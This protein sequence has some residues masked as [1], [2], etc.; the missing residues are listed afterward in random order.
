MDMN[1][2]ISRKWKKISMIV[3]GMVGLSTLTFNCAP[4]MFQSMKFGEGAGNGLLEAVEDIFSG[5]KKS[6]FAMMTAKQTY[7]TFLNVTGQE[8]AQTT[9]QLSE[10]DARFSSLSSN[11]RLSS[12]N[13]PLQMAAV[14]LAGEVCNGLVTKETA[15]AASARR[16]FSQVDFTKP[17]SGNSQAAFSATVQVMANSFW[18][19]SPTSD[20]ASLLNQFY[21]EFSATAGTNTAGTRNLYLATC[22][23]ML[24][25]Y[26]TYTY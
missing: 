7:K 10:Y 22:A 6:P 24:G 25:S 4:S 14:S 5:P 15:A 26:D 17:V 12:I 20:E 16:F 9:T 1:F 21:N 23:A 2:K 8:G 18:G 3:A 19:R 13:A 11:D